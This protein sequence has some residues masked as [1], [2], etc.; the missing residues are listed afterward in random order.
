MAELILV[1]QSLSS[2]D[3]ASMENY[4][5]AEYNIPIGVTI[6]AI[7]TNIVTSVA[8]NQLTLSW[9]K[10]HQGWQLQAQ[11]NSVQVGLSTNWFN[12]AGTTGTNQI[13][14]PLN[15]TNGS[16]FFRLMYQP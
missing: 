11:T 6:S 3:V 10:D 4:L 2:S 12:V 13:V 1:G 5:G 8:N 7:P 16:V 15:L 9:P 14:V